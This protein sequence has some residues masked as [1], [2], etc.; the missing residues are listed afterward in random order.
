MQQWGHDGVQQS[1]QMD[2]LPKICQKGARDPPPP[3]K[4]GRV[5]PKS[6]K[7]LKKVTKLSENLAELAQKQDKMT[8]ECHC[9]AK[10]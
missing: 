8:E 3:K 9:W 5:E 6:G 2:G 4:K 1:S 10:N 7:V